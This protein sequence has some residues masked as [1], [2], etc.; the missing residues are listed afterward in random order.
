VSTQ[1][2]GVFIQDVRDG[3]A[4]AELTA[5]LGELVAA[6]RQTGKGGSLTLKI[7]VKP[8]GRGS[9]VDKVVIT[10]T[11]TSKVPKPDRGQDF[12]WLTDT[13]DLSRN[14]PRQHSLDLRDATARGPST[15]KEA[16]A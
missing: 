11:V 1:A 8:A 9:D 13:N 16:N 2:F 5:Q 4:H 12:F 3:R 7:D 6:V 14:H 10:D 15:F